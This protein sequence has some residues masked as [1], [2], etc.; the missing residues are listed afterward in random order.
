MYSAEGEALSPELMLG[1]IEAIF[2]VRGQNGFVLFNSPE[3][4]WQ[5]TGSLMQTWS[6]N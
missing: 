6:T 2:E 3:L 1:F 5:M 4:E